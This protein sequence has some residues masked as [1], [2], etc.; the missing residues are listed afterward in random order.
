MTFIK[1]CQ[2]RTLR[3]KELDEILIKAGLL[4]LLRDMSH[5]LLDI[6]VLSFSIDK[7][8]RDHLVIVKFPKELF[9]RSPDISAF[10]VPSIA[11]PSALVDVSASVLHEAHSGLLTSIP[12][13]VIDVA[14][15]VLH[16]SDSV[17]SVV[18]PAP[19]VLMAT[20]VVVGTVS[21]S[22]TIDPLA[23]VPIAVR[24]VLVR[25]QLPSFQLHFVR[26]L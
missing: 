9:S 7:N 24:E 16:N 1:K 2:L 6:D 21:P 12:V 5:S 25:A 15:G 22:N 17:S 4:T 13:A 10:S 11:P 19:F 18:D 26:H 3:L 23:S 14:V 8:S 20:L